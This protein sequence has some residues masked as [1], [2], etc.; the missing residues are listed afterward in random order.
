MRSIYFGSFK[1]TYD[2][3][4]L[5]Y[6]LWSIVWFVAIADIVTTVI[7]LELGAA[8]SNPALRA[9]IDRYGV[10]GMV[11]VKVTAIFVGW[12][13]RPLIPFVYR[14]IIPAGMA[15]VWMLVVILNVHTIWLVVL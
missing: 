8:E 14:P 7:G 11:T 3:V 10:P 6:Y 12:Y 15:G 4:R 1:F 5:E 9:V 13:M 2:T